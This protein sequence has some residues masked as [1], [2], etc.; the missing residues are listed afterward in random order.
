MV[1]HKM[2][3]RF[4]LATIRQVETGLDASLLAAAVGL[5][6]DARLH[7]SSTYKSGFCEVLALLR[8]SFRPWEQDQVVGYDAQ[9]EFLL[10]GILAPRGE[11]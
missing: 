5:S 11:G 8:P 10:L 7:G 2:A 6:K 3:L 9:R 1:D 4:R